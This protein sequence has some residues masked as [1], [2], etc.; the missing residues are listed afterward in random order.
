MNLNFAIFV[1]QVHLHEFVNDVIFVFA[2]FIVLDEL[3]DELDVILVH[4]IDCLAVVDELL[5]MPE[6][7]EDTVHAPQLLDLN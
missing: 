1:N 3:P 7:G 4:F 5:A 6:A 2:A